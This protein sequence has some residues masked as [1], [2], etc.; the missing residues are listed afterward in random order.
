MKIDATYSPEF[1]SLKELLMDMA[2]EQSVTVLLDLIVTRMVLRPHVALVRIWLTQ[3]GDCNDCCSA[4]GCRTATVPGR[5][6]NVC[7]WW[8]ALVS[9]SLFQ[10]MTGLI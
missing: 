3:K 7:I 8:P 9:P 6:K 1:E 10:P 4:Q 2:Q 5:E